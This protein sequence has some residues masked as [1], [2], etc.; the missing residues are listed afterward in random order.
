MKLLN[1]FLL[2]TALF[3]TALLGNAIAEA[4][5]NTR[6]Q[7]EEIIKDYIMKNPQV[8]IDSLNKMQDQQM[9]DQVKK[10]AEGVKTHQKEL[11]EDATS[12]VVGNPKADV[13]IVEFFDY[14]C[15]YCK[16]SL[17]VVAQILKDDPNVKFIFKELPILSPDSE[18]ASRAALAVSRIN[19]DKYF[20]FHSALMKSTG[21]FSDKSIADIATKLGIDAAKLKTEMEKPEIKQVLEANQKLA[22]AIGVSGTPAFVL[23]NEMIPGAID[24]AGLKG[25]INKLRAQKP[26]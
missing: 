2:S 5:V 19:K 20:D 14:H 13:T 24:V 3:S 7:V 9:A 6:M 17:P 11:F 8:I 15:G 4:P 23:G 18:L 26:K 12:P 16:H 10:A 22:T 25:K 21:T 1:A